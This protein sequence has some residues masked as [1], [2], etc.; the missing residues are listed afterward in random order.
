M[1]HRLFCML[2]HLISAA[3]FQTK[4]KK[5]GEDSGKRR[6]QA[7]RCKAGGRAQAKG[8]HGEDQRGEDGGGHDGAGRVGGRGCAVREGLPQIPAEEREEIV[9][10]IVSNLPK[11]YAHFEEE[12]EKNR[13][14]SSLH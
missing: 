3:F 4:S 12:R 7:R 2:R 9:T 10:T 14:S 8:A 5:R 1:S 6:Q 11:I 13:K